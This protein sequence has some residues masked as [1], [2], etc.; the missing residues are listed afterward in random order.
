[1]TTAKKVTRTFLADFNQPTVS[2]IVRDDTWM[3]TYTSGKHT[4]P[5]IV[6]LKVGNRF[7]GISKSLD[8]PESPNLKLKISEFALHKKYGYVIF[9]LCAIPKN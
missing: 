9:V 3:L 4:K 5:F 6:T 8:I 7:H 1:M 2:S